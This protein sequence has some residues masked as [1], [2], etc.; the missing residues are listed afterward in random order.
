MLNQARSGVEL[1]G[2]FEKDETHNP[3]SEFER[4]RKA[5][6]PVEVSF[7]RQSQVHAPLK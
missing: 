6:P 4:M 5:G 3:Y 7:G 1:E 2:V